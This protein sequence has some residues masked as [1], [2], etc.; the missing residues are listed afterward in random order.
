[1]YYIVDRV[2]PHWIAVGIEK[3]K[4]E[5]AARIDGQIDLS[6]AVRSSGNCFGSTQRAR[7]IGIADTELI[8]KGREGSETFG[9]H[10][11]ISS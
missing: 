10:L 1:M 9:F 11:Y 4:R 3:S 7:D 2:F 8:I 5:I 6:S